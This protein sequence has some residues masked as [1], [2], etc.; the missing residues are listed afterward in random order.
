M[1]RDSQEVRALA[2]RV[3]GGT[4]IEAEGSANSKAQGGNWCISGTARGCVSRKDED[5]IWYFSFSLG[6]LYLV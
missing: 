5:S 3:S 4:V 6:L 2:M 1:S